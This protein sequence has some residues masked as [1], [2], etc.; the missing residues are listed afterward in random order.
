MKFMAKTT[1]NTATFRD[2]A[3]ANSQGTLVSNPLSGVNDGTM[4]H[5]SSVN[6]ANIFIREYIF[7]FAALVVLGYGV[8]KYRQGVIAVK[9][10]AMAGN[11][12]KQSLV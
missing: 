10:E 5:M 12:L 8:T 3:L 1:M 11:T 7:L 4:S 9:R 6:P 2:I